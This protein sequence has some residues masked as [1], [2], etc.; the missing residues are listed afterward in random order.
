MDIQEISK[1]SDT[2]NG[3][4]LPNTFILCAMMGEYKT[5]EEPIERI[6]LQ[7]FQA[8]DNTQREM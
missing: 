6:A 5:Y 7:L 8:K 2:I 4:P 3:N 1:R